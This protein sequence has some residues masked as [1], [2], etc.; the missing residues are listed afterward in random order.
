[1]SRFTDNIQALV[2]KTVQ[3]YGS[4]KG[5]VRTQLAST[6]NSNSIGIVTQLDPATN[7]N[8]VQMSDGSTVSTHPEF[9]YYRAGD[10]AVPVGPSVN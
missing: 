9:Y 5:Y 6:Q 4:Q 10:P 7:T 1:M 3:M 2:I 8:Q